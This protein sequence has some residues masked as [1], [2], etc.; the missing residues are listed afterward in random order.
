MEY[1]VILEISSDL[2]GGA[3]GIALLVPTYRI[4]SARALIAGRIKSVEQFDP[5]DSEGLA[6]R[7]K[8]LEL[9][10]SGFE[11]FDALLLKVGA[12]ALLLSFTTKIV[13]HMA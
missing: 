1:K 2:L 3:S 11:P 13:S 4:T 8:E 9:L 6:K 10:L 5:L 12:W 7:L